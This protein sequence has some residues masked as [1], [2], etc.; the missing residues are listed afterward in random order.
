[1][2][3]NKSNGVSV[4]GS[5]VDGIAP[6]EK[7]SPTPG[8]PESSGEVSQ[9]RSEGDGVE[10]L[11]DSRDFVDAVAVT[12]EELFK[13]KQEMEGIDVE[14]M[15]QEV[16][17]EMMTSQKV[18]ELESDQKPISEIIEEH[19]QSGQGEFLDALSDIDTKPQSEVKEVEIDDKEEDDSDDNIGSVSDDDNI[20]YNE[21]DLEEEGFHDLPSP[22]N[23]IKR[24]STSTDELMLG[25]RD[26]GQSSI[27][28]DIFT[29]VNARFGQRYPPHSRDLSPPGSKFDS[30]R[31]KYTQPKSYAPK[32][33]HKPYEM[34]SRPQSY[35]TYMGV[36][37]AGSSLGYYLDED[38]RQVS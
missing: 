37:T 27:V 22:K 5:S 4:D 25:F 38:E 11:E 36:P 30:L 16:K 8:D 2:D 13:P 14:G 21:N 1:M 33:L 18:M 3:V 32:K 6:E 10:D 23:T 15:E 31:S 9:N 7:N 35:K 34:R 29:D 24:Q 20:I 28:S 26:D 19:E 17:G 12:E